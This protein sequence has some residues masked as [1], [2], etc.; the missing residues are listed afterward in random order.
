MNKKIA[1]NIIL[2]LFFANLQSAFCYTLTSSELKLEVLSKITPE[3]SAQLKNYSSDFKINIYGISSNP[4]ITAEAAKPKIE[5]ISQNKNFSQNS[6]KRILI[7]DSNNNLIK[8][9][10]INVQTKVYADVL[11]ASKMIS[12]NEKITSENTKIE[13]KEISKH[14]GKTYSKHMDG[15]V[16]KR[17]YQ[18]ESIIFADYTE[19]QTSILKNSNIDIVFESKNLNIKL[20]GKALKDGAI[21][22]TIL[23]RSDKYNKT[24]TGIVKSENE[25]MVRI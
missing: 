8:A 1:K 2:F 21:G 16:A 25:V 6:Y 23:V 10:P 18:A 15:I 3:I 9:F 19:K 22:D 12:F 4:I 13:R 20:R 7:K 5:V 17:N 11:T 24:Y 14:L